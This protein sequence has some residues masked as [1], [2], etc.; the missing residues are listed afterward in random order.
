MTREEHSETGEVDEQGKKFTPRAEAA[1][2][3]QGAEVEEQGYRFPRGDG[4]GH[5]HPET[6]DSEKNER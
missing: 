1:A 2:D 3:E 5:R 6:S 4:E